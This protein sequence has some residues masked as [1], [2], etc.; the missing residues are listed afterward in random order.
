MGEPAGTVASRFTWGVRANER[1]SGGNGGK[2]GRG[3]SVAD[4]VS[5]GK[6][7]SLMGAL[8]G[9]YDALG[10]ETRGESEGNVKRAMDLLDDVYGNLPDRFKM[11]AAMA[12]EEPATMYEAL[13]RHTQNATTKCRENEE[14]VKNLPEDIVR[15][16][17]TASKVCEGDV[18]PMLDDDDAMIAILCLKALKQTIGMVRDASR[19]TTIL[20]D[21]PI[22]GKELVNNLL[23][24]SE[25]DTKATMHTT[26][27]MKTMKKISR[28]VTKELSTMACDAESTDAQYL[29]RALRGLCD[30][31]HEH[32]AIDA[33]IQR[34]LPSTLMTDVRTM[35]RENA[36]KE[37]SMDLPMKRARLAIALVCE[38]YHSR[39]DFKI[40][41]IRTCL[42]EDVDTALPDQASFFALYGAICAPSSGPARFVER[43]TVDQIRRLTRSGMIFPKDI[44]KEQADALLAGVD[45]YIAHNVKPTDTKF[46]VPPPASK[47]S[48]TQQQQKSGLKPQA[49]DAGNMTTTITP[50]KK[51]RP[52]THKKTCTICNVELAGK[53][54][55]HLDNVWNLHIKSTTHRNIE[56]GRAKQK[57][58]QASN[59]KSKKRKI[60]D[61]TPLNRSVKGKLMDVP[62]PPSMTGADPRGAAI[63]Q[64]QRV[65]GA[66]VSSEKKVSRQVREDMSSDDTQVADVRSLFADA[67]STPR[68]GGGQRKRLDKYIVKE[69]RPPRRDGQFYCKYWM[70]LGHCWNND[71]CTFRHAIPAPGSPCDSFNREDDVL[72]ESTATSRR[73]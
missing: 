47:T 41:K 59:S 34:A 50:V 26:L 22:A 48:A 3:V 9:V 18:M 60:V 19:S 63:Q 37:G 66:Q 7:K 21:K 23:K 42:S 55:A 45:Q 10:V 68:F 31:L 5:L 4:T 71:Q 58:K 14:I 20:D 57:Q 56:A 30:F 69:Y 16:I 39:D 72:P 38:A 35:Y 53:C 54:E 43:A 12:A 24:I 25:L 67:S 27:I 15:D 70:R 73:R 46:T 32:K 64:L 33:F 17:D 52:Y 29:W 11:D 2:D 6:F 40:E 49:L 51:E 44:S 65:S 62:P 1:V 8:T 61:E 13:A 36:A 28:D